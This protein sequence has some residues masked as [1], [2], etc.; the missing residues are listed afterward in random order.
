MSPPKQATSTTQKGKPKYNTVSQEKI[1]DVGYIAKQEALPILIKQVQAQ[2]E[3]GF[4]KQFEE[5][6]FADLNEQTNGA[7][8]CAD[9]FDSHAYKT[10]KTTASNG[11]F[12]KTR[13][14]KVDHINATIVEPTQNAHSIGSIR[15]DAKASVSAQGHILLRCTL[16]DRTITKKVCDS[17][18]TYN[19][20]IDLVADV[21]VQNINGVFRISVNPTAKVKMKASTTCQKIDFLHGLI[22]YEIGNAVADGIT[23]VA[24]AYVKEAIETWSLR[25][26]MDQAYAVHK[27]LVVFYRTANITFIPKRRILVSSLLLINVTKVNETK[28][29]SSAL[30]H[31]R[32][33]P[34]WGRE[35]SN[36]TL[37]TLVMSNAAL[38]TLSAAARYSYSSVFT[39]ESNV[40]GAA[41]VTS[42]ELGKTTIPAKQPSLNFISMLQNQVGV[43]LQCRTVGNATRRMDILRAQLNNVKEEIMP[44][45]VN[46]SIRL[47]LSNLSVKQAV[48]R[49]KLDKV[50]LSKRQIKNSLSTTLSETRQSIDRQLRS[51]AIAPISKRLL[52]NGTRPVLTV[53]KRF[54]QVE[55]SNNKN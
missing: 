54:I 4:Q 22:S 33:P 24:N 27:G 14:I 53:G 16:W 12:V 42:I 32:L 37:V 30:T 41:I 48:V 47:S 28:T 38:E 51:S 9:Y 29:F 19:G 13:T 8:P 6:Q 3:T 44:F 52:P 2:I 36:D 49:T 5:I 23:P 31:S 7:N 26:N 17:D 39:H 11:K 43:T 34:D 15:V 20:G 1:G 55:L 50:I 21:D 45:F 18:V 25:L 35:R 40:G 10:E 46:Q